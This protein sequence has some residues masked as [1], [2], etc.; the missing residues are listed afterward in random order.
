MFISAVR[1]QP[2]VQPKHVV[3]QPVVQY[4]SKTGTIAEEVR[5]KVEA[6]LGN[7]LLANLKAKR[8]AAAIARGSNFGFNSNAE[9]FPEKRPVESETYLGPGYYEVPNPFDRKTQSQVANIPGVNISLPPRSQTFLSQAPRFGD[10]KTKT[11]IPGPG[12][13]SNEDLNNWF[14]RSY[15]M[16]FTE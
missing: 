11:A 4:D 10:D 13:Y 14:K 16:I 15:N 7:P 6:G 9:R 3:E 2:Y 12:H 5:H 1:R 8:Q